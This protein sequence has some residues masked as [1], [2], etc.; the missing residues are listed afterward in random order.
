VMLCGKMNKTLRHGVGR[1]RSETIVGANEALGG[2]QW[3][4]VN[5]VRP[6]VAVAATHY[7]WELPGLEEV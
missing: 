3:S 2:W 4:Q 1:R 6:S 7:P 5:D